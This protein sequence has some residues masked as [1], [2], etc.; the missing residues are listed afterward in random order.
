MFT[1]MD[2]ILA[3]QYKYKTGMAEGEARK[4][5]EIA[6]ALKAKGIESVIIAECT[7]LTEEQ[8]SKL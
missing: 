8:V 3:E 2:K 1:E 6:K 4:Q 7:G 5:Q